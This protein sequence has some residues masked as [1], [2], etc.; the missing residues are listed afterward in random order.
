[1]GS[2]NC[3]DPGI[4]DHDRGW[5]EIFRRP[6]LTMNRKSGTNSQMSQIILDIIDASA[7]NVLISYCTC[8]AYITLLTRLRDAKS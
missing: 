1:M 7:L 6:T 8:R 5:L 2:A 3:D 4:E